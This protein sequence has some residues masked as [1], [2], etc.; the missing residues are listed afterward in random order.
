MSEALIRAQIETILETVPGIGVVYD[1]ERY[2]RSLGDYFKLMTPV[3]QDAVN[4]WVI[5]RE[6]TKSRQVT[7]GLLGQIE[8]VHSYRIAG[9]Y[10]MDDAAG[11]EKVFQAIL[12][13]IFTAFKANGTLNGTATSHDQI[14]IDEVTVCLEDEFGSSLYHVADCTLTVTER[15]DIMT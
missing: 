15:V 14:Q 9:L 13:G 6:E 12:D 10:D 5:H 3:G 1:Y 2:A 7:M 8:R 4:G 11:S